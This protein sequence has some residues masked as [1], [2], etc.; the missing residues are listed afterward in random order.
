MYITIGRDPKSNIVI[1][2]QDTVSFNHATIEY[3]NGSYLF[4]DDSSNGTLINGQRLH[5]S[6]CSLKPGDVIMLAGVC[7]LKWERIFN[8]VNGVQPQHKPVDRPTQMMNRGYNVPQQQYQS[9]QYQA[10]QPQY[11]APQPQY[12]APQ[13]QYQQQPANPN[14]APSSNKPA[15]SERELNKWNWGAFLTGWLWG[16][17]NNVYWTLVALIPIPF[18]ALIVNIIAGV[19]GTRQAWEN[20]KWKDEEFAEF[21]K[22]QHGWAIA[23]FIIFGG[24]IALAIILW[25]TIIAAFASIF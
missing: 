7:Q 12:Q 11:P 10:P 16:V 13:P 8:E 3:T 9:P 6:S 23:G 21:A 20:G 18:V 22:K 1:T 5:H 25:S 4:I 24:S 15:I 2:G 14:P 19:K 17:F